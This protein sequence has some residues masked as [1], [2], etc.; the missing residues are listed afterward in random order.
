[1]AQPLTSSI[2]PSIPSVSQDLWCQTSD[3]KTKAALRTFSDEVLFKATEVIRCSLPQKILELTE[4]IR[5]SETDENYLFHSKW[6]TK[7]STLST[8]HKQIL[9]SPKANMTTFALVDVSNTAGS[10]LQES[11]NKPEIAN[12]LVGSPSATNKSARG[13]SISQQCVPAEVSLPSSISVSRTPRHV[14]H[15]FEAIDVQTK[16]IV[17]LLDLAQLYLIMKTPVA[18]EGNNT[19]VEIQQQCARTLVESRRFVVGCENYPKLYHTQRAK[20]ASKCL[21][22]P[23]LEDYQRALVERDHEECKDSRYLLARLRTQCIAV[24]DMLHK[25][26]EKVDDPKGLS[27]G[28]GTVGMY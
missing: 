10:S 13:I 7:W 15:L 22:Y 5:L 12:G 2:A 19:G 21:K 17:E 25:N 14:L 11:P 18:E 1:M 28:G 20:L 16:H 3:R 8:S 23:Q 26:F 24:V 4:M 6:D 9:N 27:R